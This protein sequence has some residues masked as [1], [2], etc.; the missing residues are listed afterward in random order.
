MWMV[1]KVQDTEVLRGSGCLGR[2]HPSTTC[3]RT[4]PAR[5]GDEMETRRAAARHAN[6]ELVQRFLRDVMPL[7]DQLHRAARRMTRNSSDAED[8]VQ[9]TLIRAF[10][11]LADTNTATCTRG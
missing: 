11:G 4:N 8:L 10:T 5:E 3:M 2:G 1:A 9:D 6:P 7:H